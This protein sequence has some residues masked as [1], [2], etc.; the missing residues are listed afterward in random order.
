MT[1]RHLHCVYFK[2]YDVNDPKGYCL[3]HQKEIQ[4]GFRPHCPNIVLRPHL[5]LSYY[6]VHKGLCD[7]WECGDKKAL[8]YLERVKLND[9]P[10]GDVE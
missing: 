10:K 8:E 9:Y 3:L 6:L 4:N 7:S 5:L 1:D 2:Y